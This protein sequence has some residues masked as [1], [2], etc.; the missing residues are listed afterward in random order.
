M[1]VFQTKAMPTDAPV[2]EDPAMQEQIPEEGDD[3]AVSWSGDEVVAGDGIEISDPA[4]A[5]SRFTGE[6]GLEAW[7]DIREDRT[8]M[9]WVREP[10]GTTFRYVDANS[11]ARDVT[12][13]GMQEVTEGLAD[14]EAEAEAEPAA[15]AG[16]DTGVDSALELLEGLT[17]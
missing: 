16:D 15:G 9:G 7:L 13:A 12:A 6:Q 14:P 11:W 5:Y 17:G 4:D 10:D 1:T 8:L 2:P 3:S